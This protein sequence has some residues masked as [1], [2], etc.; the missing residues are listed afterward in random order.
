MRPMESSWKSKQGDLIEV[1]LEKI[2]DMRHPLV[3]V[4]NQINW[5]ALEEK[6]GAFYH[7]K[8]GRP[9]KPTQL[10]AGLHYLKHM[11][12]VSDEVVVERWVENPYW[13]YF[14]GMKYFQHELPIHPTQMTKWRKKI[15]TEGM[16]ELLRHTVQAAVQSE[17][18]QTRSFFNLNVDTTVQPKAIAFPTDA[19]LY[20]RMLT[21]LVK[22]AKQQ[23]MPLRQS[24]HRV[25]RKALV[26]VG[27]LGHAG[28]TREMRRE[29]RRLRS[30]LGRVMRDIQRRC[31]GKPDWK[32]AF[33][34]KLTQAQKL[35]SQQRKDK[36][37]LYSI[38]APETECIC[39]GKAHQRYE[40]G[41]KVG[42]VMTSAEGLV[43]GSLAFHGNPYDGHTL[44]PCMEQAERIVNGKLVG[45]V[46]TDQGYRGHNYTGPATVYLA[47]RSWKRIHG[48]IKRWF[49]RR[50]AVE[51]IIGHM[52]SDGRLGRN[53]LLGR[54]G[55][56]FNALLCAC[57][58]N[59]RLLLN[60]CGRSVRSL[61]V[62][63]NFGPGFFIQWSFSL[64]PEDAY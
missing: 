22:L 60:W 36:D 17:A 48:R 6:F 1:E 25:S 15:G 19:K 2:I 43:I 47:G 27:R 57:G 51:P 20:Y 39:K 5:A 23:G 8:Q 58:Q 12:N 26:R 52:K 63:F 42:L 32:K 13:Q 14:C 18:V 34:D 10:M 59:L 40:F 56:H 49:R 44:K 21:H 38:H 3:L 61:F 55:D 62:S 16:E 24:Y 7:Y 29:T 35:W 33:K 45:N 9:G 54:L 37:K 28:R 30:Y 31:T 53:Y 50:P 64:L 11:Y 41:N 46:F 4:R